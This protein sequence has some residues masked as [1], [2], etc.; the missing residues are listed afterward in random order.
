MPRFQVELQ[1]DVGLVIVVVAIM[2]PSCRR[3]RNQVSSGTVHYS[4]TTYS[5]LRYSITTSYSI[6]TVL[7]VT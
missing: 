4:S 2:Q 7:A 5:T 3:Y 6:R 1:P